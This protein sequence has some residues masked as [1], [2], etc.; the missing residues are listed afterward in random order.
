VPA[1]AWLSS[2]L[3]ELYSLSALSPMSLLRE[4]VSIVAGLICSLAGRDCVDYFNF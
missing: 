4:D 2:F 3:P 1:K